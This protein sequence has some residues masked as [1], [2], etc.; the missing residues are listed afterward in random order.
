MCNKCGAKTKKKPRE[1]KKETRLE[2]CARPWKV[3]TNS[4]PSSW[5]GPRL[6]RG[7]PSRRPSATT[8]VFHFHFPFFFLLHIYFL[9]IYIYV[10]IH[11]H[12]CVTTSGMSVAMR[13]AAAA[14][15]LRSARC[16]PK[17]LGR[18]PRSRMLIPF[19]FLDLASSFPWHTFSTVIYYILC[20]K[21]LPRKTKLKSL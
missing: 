12:T 20:R 9:K 19:F 16:E 10:Y 14:P 13:R 18:C 8:Y 3:R 4:E 21:S 2:A 1:N 5:R 6:L 15:P 17:G 11:T 7:M